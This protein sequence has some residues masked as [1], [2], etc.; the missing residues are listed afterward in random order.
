MRRRE[1]QPRYCLERFKPVSTTD[2]VEGGW[3]WG[4]RLY[5]RLC[6]ARLSSSVCGRIVERAGQHDAGLLVSPGKRAGDC[7]EMARR[8]TT[9]RGD[10]ENPDHPSLLCCMLANLG[11]PGRSHH[12]LNATS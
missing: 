7:Y 3:A 12:N 11:R 8:V 6:L 9:R 10:G 4:G 5:A 2:E 1:E